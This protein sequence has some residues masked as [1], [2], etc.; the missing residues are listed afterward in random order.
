VAD[1][2]RQ[3]KSLSKLLAAD[4][5]TLAEVEQSAINWNLRETHF[6]QQ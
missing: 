3:R 1:A 6:V 2:S 4:R 5:Q